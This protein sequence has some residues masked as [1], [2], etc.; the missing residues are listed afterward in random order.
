MGSR[1]TAEAVYDVMADAR[2]YPEWWKPV[3]LSVEGDEKVTRITS[4]GGSRTP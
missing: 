1:G 3:Y 2:T 4:R